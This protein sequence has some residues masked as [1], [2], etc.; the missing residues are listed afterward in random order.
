MLLTL[1]VRD[2]S[3]VVVSQVV[4]IDRVH[5]ECNMH[6]GD[7]GTHLHTQLHTIHTVHTLQW[8]THETI[9]YSLQLQSL[10]VTETPHT[11]NNMGV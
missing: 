1:T 3:G 9:I 8:A 6:T 5:R 4:F 11:C 10:Q 7:I 2:T